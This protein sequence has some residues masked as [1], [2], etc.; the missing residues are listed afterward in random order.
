VNVLYAGSLVNLMTKQV[1][2]AF[3]AAAGYAVS[4]ISAGST[5]LATAIKGKV[6]VGDVFI[7][8][9][10][11]ADASL[12]G[13]SNGDWVSWYGTFATS[14]LVLGY[15]PKSS[16]AADLKSKPWYD[17]ITE[18]GFKLGFTDPATDPKGV[19]AVEALT[20]TAKSKKLSALSTV[21]ADKNDLFPEETLVGR[22]QSGQLDAGFFYTAEAAAA[23]I[24]TVPLT[25]TA[26]KATYTIT[27][28]NKAKHEAA[29]E[30]F[31]SYLLGPSGQPFLKKDGFALTTPP[32]VTG[33]GVPSGL[34]SL[35]S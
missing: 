27:I 15:N 28:L 4:G 29:A 32:T 13:A 6:D 7:S 23:G 8:A 19:L 21:A 25:G 3:Q 31:I 2:P 24:P 18:P 22:L 17:V 16:F 26:L 20:D 12:T 33:K 5:V 30:A 14:A 34:S 1:G 10:P 9:S 35:F 11:K